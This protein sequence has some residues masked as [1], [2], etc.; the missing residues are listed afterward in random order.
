M[1]GSL[2]DFPAKSKGVIITSSELSKAAKELAIYYRIEVYRA[3][4]LYSGN[5]RQALTRLDKG[6]SI[7]GAAP[8][9]MS[10]GRLRVNF[11]CGC[12]VRFCLCAGSVFERPWLLC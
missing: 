7:L 11:L 12:R 6:Q 1:L 5:R 8:V 9:I 3:R 10:M 2:R 4:R